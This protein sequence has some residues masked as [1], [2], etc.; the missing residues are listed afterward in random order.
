MKLKKAIE[1]GYVKLNIGSGIGANVKPDYVNIDIVNNPKIDLVTDVC[2]LPMVDSIADE[3]ICEHVIE[4]LQ[5]KEIL[6]ALIEWRRVLKPGARF[7]LSCPNVL[8][9][10]QKFLDDPERRWTKWATN[11]YGGQLYDSDVHQCGFSPESL[12]EYFIQA[13]FKNIVIKPLGD[14][15]RGIGLWC[16]A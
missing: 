11:I 9:C 13:G 6:P 15:N 3:V 14:Y 12:K 16:I 10:M 7:Y 1:Q 5:F 8:V 4:H 2:S